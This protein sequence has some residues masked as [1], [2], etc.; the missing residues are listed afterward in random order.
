MLHFDCSGA[1][2]CYMLA[3]AVGKEVVMNYFPERVERFR[4]R[5]EE[6]EQEL[7]FFLLFLRLFPMSPNWA[8]NMA[9]GVLGVP[10]HLFFLSVF[11]GLMPYNYLCV[12]SGVLIADIKEVEMNLNNCKISFKIIC[13]QVGDILS[14]SNL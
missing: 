1:S 14:W 7:P 5:L 12:T 4:E 8:L 2:F 9:S 6:N 3:R 11:F 13:H 10:L